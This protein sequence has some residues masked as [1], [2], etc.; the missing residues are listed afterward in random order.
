VNGSAMDVETGQR[1]STTITLSSGLSEQD[2]AASM[3]ANRS[4]Q[5]AGHEAA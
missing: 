1:A 4:M 5:L 2:I 3:E